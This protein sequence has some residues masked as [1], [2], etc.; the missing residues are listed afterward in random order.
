MEWP[1]T[2]WSRDDL[3][4][5]KLRAKKKRAVVLSEEA[6]TEPEIRSLIPGALTVFLW[7]FFTTIYEADELL[8]LEAEDP[9]AKQ[10]TKVVI[11]NGRVF[12]GFPMGIAT[13]V[14]TVSDVAE[15]LPSSVEE[16]LSCEIIVTQE[17]GKM[18]TSLKVESRMSLWQSFREAYLK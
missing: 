13:K 9:I 14:T 7:E 15:L 2:K 16:I 10:D 8:D 11:V 1:R 6:V 18:L 12:E 17:E 4:I 3:I 5:R